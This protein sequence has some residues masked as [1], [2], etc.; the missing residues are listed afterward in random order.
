MAD[1]SLDLLSVLAVTC[2]GH[3]FTAPALNTS[4]ENPPYTVGAISMARRRFF[5]RL[6][7]KNEKFQNIFEI[8]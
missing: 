6:A 3:C 8:S 1:F 4:K 7:L 2:F 5:D